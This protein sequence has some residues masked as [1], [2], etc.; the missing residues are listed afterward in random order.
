MSLVVI[1]GSSLPGRALFA[2]DGS[3]SIKNTADNTKQFAWNLASMT[4]GKTLTI[5]PLLTTSQTLQIPNITATD[6]VAVL[7]LAQTFTAAQTVNISGGTS[8][9]TPTGGITLIC[10]ATT[11]EIALE[12]YAGGFRMVGYIAEGTPAVPSAPI[13]GRV[14]F[15]L[16]AAGW[17]SAAT[18]TAGGTYQMLTTEA[19]GSGRGMQ[20]I[21]NGTTTGTT[22]TANWM[23]L[24][25]GASEPA[26]T[27]A[28]G[29]GAAPTTGN[30][31]LQLAAGTTKASG[32][33]WGADCFVYRDAA[34]S[35]TALQA[36]TID[37]GTGASSLASTVVGFKV[38]GA[39]GVQT[40]ISVEDYGVSP[41]TD[42][43]VAENTRAAPAV[44]LSTRQLIAI[45]GFGWTSTGTW[46]FGGG[47]DL[48]ADGNWVNATNSGSYWRFRICANGSFASAIEYMRLSGGGLSLSGGGA[49]AATVGNGLLQLASGST[50]ANGIAWGTDTFLYRTGSNALKTDGV[51][52][53]ASTTAA[54][55]ST[56]GALT[57]GGGLGVN[58]ALWVSSATLI[59]SSTTLTN[60]AAAAVGTLLNAPAAGNPTKWIPINDNGTTRYLPAW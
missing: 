18:W 35:L 43:Y 14:L 34:T 20:H 24:A 1:G 23:W 50:K 44:L 22:T 29:I 3:F 56:T 53:I 51:L 60:G 10:G 7:G 26:S 4:T 30:G 27:A 49:L 32:I 8:T 37:L 45:R 11:P 13:S 54:T 5:K 33:A 52:A 57:I 48:Q 17:T 55:S 25:S 31:L 42:S 16:I 38:R 46:T 36:L 21:W 40:G 19:W 6:T 28:L 12:R 2:L 41:T 58:G 59:S 39:D 47:I 9:R 15:N